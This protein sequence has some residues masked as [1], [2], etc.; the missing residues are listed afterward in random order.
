MDNDA[1]PIVVEETFKAPIDDVWKAIVDA[2]QM[3]QWYFETIADFEPEKGFETRFNVRAEGRDYLHLW[4][5]TDVVPGKRITY[6]WRY[7]GYPG[8]SSLTWELSETPDGTKLTLT[9]DGIET[10]PND[11]PL[12][13]REACEEGWSY[14]I[15]KS[16][17]AFLERH[18]GASAASPA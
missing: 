10:F 1:R 4:K 5:V 16:L 18:G 14:F 15:Q 13:S 12:F 11:D 2:D 7:G 8:D 6:D 9:H 17:K 3:R